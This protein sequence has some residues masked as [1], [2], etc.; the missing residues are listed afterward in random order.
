VEILKRLREA[1]RRKRPEIRIKD[2]ILHH[3]NA[4]AHKVLSVK[5]FL[6]QKSIFEMQHPS[7]SPDLAPNDF[8][9]FPKN[10]VCLKGTKI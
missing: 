2:W 10:T 4:P 7:Y 5:Q 3:D 9:L 8:W 1:V 6:A